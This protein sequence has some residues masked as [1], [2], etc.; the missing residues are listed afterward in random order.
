VGGGPMSERKRLAVSRGVTGSRRLVASWQRSEDFR[1]SLDA[2]S[3]AFV[4]A[5][6]DESLF[7]E[8]GHHVLTGL[9]RTL[10]DEPVSLMLT[11]S[12]GL[13]LS[14]VCGERTLLAALDDVFLAPGFDYSE[15]QAG[16]TGLGLALA[17][18]TASL[19]RGE[20]HYCTG[21]WGYTCAAAPVED[22]YSGEEL[23]SINLTTWSEQSYGLLLALAETAARNTE[24]LMLARGHG[25]APRPNRRG[26]VTR[27]RVAETG[28]A[29]ETD[30]SP[31]W[32]S[33]YDE[34]VAASQD[35]RGTAVVGEPGTGRATLLGAALIQTR[36]GWRVLVA[37]PPEPADV[38]AWLAAWS[39]ELA[40]PRTAIV[41]GDVDRLPASAAAEL[42]GRMAA[43]PDGPPPLALTASDASAVPDA[44]AG[45]VDTVVE[46]P[47]LRYRLADVVP[48]A[49]HLAR[50]VRGREIRFHPAAEHALQ[51]YHWPENVGQLREVVRAAAARSTFVA[52]RD[53]S[54]EIFTG[55]TCKLTRIETLERDAIVRCLS[56]QGAT[57]AHAAEELGM[58]R[59]TIYR[60]IA[61]YGIRLP[62][63]TTE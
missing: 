23:G 55:S 62:N 44:L 39:P 28:D 1:V 4:G 3:P 21:L 19:V 57:P 25:R 36:P 16:T 6:D 9:Q 45:R 34:A 31:D 8:S 58:S 52:V 29:V 11:D 47:A 40:K 12:D 56:E 15:S 41:L 38:D 30:L 24:A 42:A 27:F 7:F 22:P 10:A 37:R 35:N 46:L 26:H 32:R 49:R 51:T 20:E 17:D 5:V 33:A 43:A 18:R 60:R 14:R 48:L 13:V 53:L 2:V 59:A 50:R 61:H 54:P 63:D